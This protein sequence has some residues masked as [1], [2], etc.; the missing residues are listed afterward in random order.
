MYQIIQPI[1]HSGLQ[2]KDQWKTHLFYMSFDF[3]L[4]HIFLT[5]L[6]IK[7]YKHL[8]FLFCARHDS[9]YRTSD[10][11]SLL[12]KEQIPGLLKDEAL[13]VFHFWYRTWY[14]TLWIFFFIFYHHIHDTAYLEHKGEMGQSK[15]SVGS[16]LIPF[17]R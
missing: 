9:Y 1:F 16:D 4:I 3:L 10:Q 11:I 14:L 7:L 15:N 17:I 5:L 8:G 13:A 6:E 2:C 12:I